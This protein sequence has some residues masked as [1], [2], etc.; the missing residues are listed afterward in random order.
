[1]DGDD[2]GVEGPAMAAAAGGRGQLAG[3]YRRMGRLPPQR[4]VVL[5]GKQRVAG[6]NPR[7]PE[8]GFS[9]EHVPHVAHAEMG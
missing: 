8:E 7:D 5:A 1:M 9:G 2:D 4:R 3:S 6:A